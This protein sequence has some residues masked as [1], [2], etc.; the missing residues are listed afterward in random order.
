MSYDIYLVGSQCPTCGHSPESFDFPD[1]TYNLTPIFDLALTG[2]DMPNPQVG[3]MAVVLLGTKTDRPRGLRLLSGRKAGDTVKDIE[4]ALKRM[5][6]PSMHEKFTKLLPSNGWGT[7]EGA[8]E[9]MLIL[10][11]K[12]KEFPNATWDIG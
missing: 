11:R 5:N 6:D 1:P 8:T 4:L 12:A 7:L 9:T 10:H 3:E 2:E